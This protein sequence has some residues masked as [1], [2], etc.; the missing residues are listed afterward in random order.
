[1]SE[2]EVRP[3]TSSEFGLV[4][5]FTRLAIHVPDG[6]QWDLDDLVD[7]VPQ[8]RLYWEGFG[9]KPTDVAWCAEQGD[10]VI[11]IASA[12]VLD[13]DPAGY[14]NVGPGV[15]EVDVSIFPEQRGRGIGT[16][17]L[18]ALLQDLAQRGHDRVSL[19]VDRTNDKARRV[20]ERLGFVVVLDDPAR[21]D[22]L[23]ACNL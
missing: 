5:E 4:R 11:G 3:L 21:T 14:G 12:R 7:N 22:L 18:T 2:F 9:T 16:T 8:I 19:S 10:T 15:P 6:E 20:Y 13:G 17:L 1:M 23:L